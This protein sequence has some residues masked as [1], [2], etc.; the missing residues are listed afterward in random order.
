MAK[1]Y[2]RMLALQPKYPT[3]EELL[4]KSRPNY[5]LEFCAFS[6]NY[7]SKHSVVTGM[8]LCVCMYI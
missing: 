1:S 2:H 6:E 8:P 4:N 7:V 5:R 3:N